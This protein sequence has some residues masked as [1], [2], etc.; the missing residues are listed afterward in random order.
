M[1]PCSRHARARWRVPCKLHFGQS[2]AKLAGM[3]R[4]ADGTV[5]MFRSR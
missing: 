3:S 4:E 5:F 2:D 1:V